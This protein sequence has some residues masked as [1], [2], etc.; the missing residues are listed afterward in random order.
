MKLANEERLIWTAIVLTTLTVL[1]C[2]GSCTG[3]LCWGFY[4][5]IQYWTTP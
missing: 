4:R 3:F 5:V 1:A 2:F